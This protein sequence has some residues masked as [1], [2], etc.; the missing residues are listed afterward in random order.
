MSALALVMLL[1][2]PTAASAHTGAGPTHGLLHG[3][4]HPLFGMDHLLA[5]VA[6]GLWAAQRGGRA[7]W[8]LPAAFVATMVVGGVLGAAGVGLPGV[9]AG[10][11]LSVLV[12]GALVAA[13]ARLPIPTSVAAVAL[14]ALFH[15]HAHGAEMPHS[16]SGLFYGI[17]FVVATALLHAT[18]IAVVVALQGARIE[19]HPALVRLAGVSISVAGAALWLF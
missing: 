13:A 11:L 9:E 7:V 5:M 4:T 19:R 12:L 8:A 15:G 17:G 18:G 1:L 10:I 14:F 3:L 2:V 6:V 16:T